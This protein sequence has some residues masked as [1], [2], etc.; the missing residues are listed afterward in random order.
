M[1]MEDEAEMIRKNSGLAMMVA[2][3][4]HGSM[5]RWFGGCEIEDVFQEALI[6]LLRANK[7]FDPSKGFQFSTYAVKVM[8][9]HINKKAITIKRR[10]TKCNIISLEGFIKQDEEFDDEYQKMIA[11]Y[12]DPSNRLQQEILRQKIIVLAECDERIINGRF[13][14]KTIPEIAAEIGW[15]KCTVNSHIQRYKYRLR[16]HKELLVNLEQ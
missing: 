3:R 4:M 12:D 11:Y 14:D 2:K 15:K 6:A 8:Y 1:Y 9:Y 5:R 16:K 10:M 7:C 13:N